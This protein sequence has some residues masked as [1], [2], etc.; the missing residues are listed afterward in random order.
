MNDEQ[1]KEYIASIPAM[2]IGE[3]TEALAIA[4]AFRVRNSGLTATKL[5]AESFTVAVKVKKARK[6]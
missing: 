2:E 4:L 1:L 3:Q 5:E 6:S